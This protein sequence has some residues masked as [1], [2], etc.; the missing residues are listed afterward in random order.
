MSAPLKNYFLVYAPDLPNAQR[1]KHSPEHMKQNV[2][3][4]QSGCIVA[5]GGLLPQDVNSSDANVLGKITGSFLVVQAETMETAWE[6]LKKDAFYTSGEV[7]DREKI[8]VTPVFVG[9][10]SVE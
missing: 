7:W 4:V 6:T 3:L 8:T 10:P 2:P 5:G 1:A 9:V